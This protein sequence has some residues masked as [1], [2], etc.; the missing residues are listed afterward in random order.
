R[1]TTVSVGFVFQAGDGMRDDLVTGVQSV[2]F[3]SCSPV[4]SIPTLSVHAQSWNRFN[5]G[6]LNPGADGKARNNMYSHLRYARLGVVREVSVQSYCVPEGPRQ[7]PGI[8]V[9]ACG[10]FH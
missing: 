9:I 8:R 5:R 4:E 7:N 1:G 2:L 3:R 10:R 6:A